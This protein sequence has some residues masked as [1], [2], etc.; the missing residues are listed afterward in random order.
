[1]K[2]SGDGQGAFCVLCDNYVTSDSVTGI[3]HQAPGFGE[4][5]IMGQ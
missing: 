5:V 3:V 2:Q 4:V 1:M